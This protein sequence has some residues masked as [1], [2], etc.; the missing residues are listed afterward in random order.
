M[1]TVSDNILDV[2]TLEPRL[3]HAT[4]FEYFD[5]LNAGENFIIH[6]D[7]DP[8][9]LYFQLVNM[10]GDTFTWDYIEQGPEWWKIRITKR[11]AEADT[12]SHNGEELNVTLLEPWLK[13]DTIF[14]WFECLKEGESFTIKNDHDPRP[15]YYHFMDMY[16]SIFTWE[17]LEEGPEWW[18][19]KVSKLEINNATETNSD[20]EEILDV[21][22]LPPSLKHATIF[23]KIEDLEAGKTFLIHVDH[24]PKPLY[25]HIS[26]NYG[27]AYTW[28]YLEQGPV[29]WKVRIGK[30]AT[31]NSAQSN[32]N[33]LN[34]TTLEP[35][36]KHATIFEWYNKLSAGENFE[37]HND[38]DPRPLYFQL[39]NMHGDK[40]FT[41]E[42]LE[43]GPEW[44]KIKITK[45]KTV[46]AAPAQTEPAATTTATTS[47]NEDDGHILDVTKLE[48]RRKHPTIFEHFD[49]LK[50]G[51]SFTIHND[52]DPKPLYYQML[53]E[54]GNIFTWEYL[55]Q[56]PV[57]WK[58]KIR[59]RTSGEEDATLGEIVSK[60][61]RKAEIFKK[62]GLDFCCKGDK[63]VKEACAEKG[64][65]VTKVEQELQQV[66]KV[67]NYRAL[68]YTDWNPDFLADFIANTHHAFTWKHMPDIRSYAA[69]VL[70]VHGANH[71]ELKRVQELVEAIHDKLMPSMSKEEHGLFPHI[72]Q[73]KVDKNSVPQNVIEL[74]MKVLKQ[75]HENLGAAL[76]ELR[77]VTDNYTL[78]QDACASYTLLFSL[79]QALEEDLLLH[80]HLESNILLP[81]VA[82]LIK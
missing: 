33:V 19:V 70:Q 45:N 60:D 21:T 44:W 12:A 63:T 62:Y 46:E 20:G 53:G 57:W 27:D 14:D 22:K 81:K 68:P 40:A 47:D 1:E 26:S 52:H 51:E 35:R 13:H 79:L 10:R 71:A 50:E 76:H 29:W 11:G 65:D 23:S 17:Y 4:I 77:Q 74:E 58:V 31:D 34:V 82:T 75:V 66:D 49:A 30:K 43:Q 78:P 69:K 2:T 73:I 25:Y 6:N 72:K 8:K 18:K 32:T 5:K 28:E 41:W 61:I 3:K 67:Q 16:G 42:Y 36:L 7:H 9:P 24:D 80:I 54:R 48:P 37:L 15:L 38:H 56:G 39:V 55:E 59:K 64:L